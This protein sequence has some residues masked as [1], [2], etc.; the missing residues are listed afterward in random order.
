MKRLVPILGLVLVCSLAYTAEV[1]SADL[2]ITATRT[3]D[4]TSQIVKTSTEYE[5]KNNGKSPISSFLHGVSAEDNEHL[6]WILAN[7]EK[8]DGKKLKTAK[9][10]VQSAPK[11]QVFYRIDLAD[12]IE[13]G[14]TAKVHVRTEV[15][16]RLK[17]Y[18]ATIVQSENQ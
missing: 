11:T 2:S 12:P 18:P 13:A 9:V 6:A 4:V 10:D 15:T 8:R 5:I 3:V 7:A 16:Q 1:P 17:P 14:A